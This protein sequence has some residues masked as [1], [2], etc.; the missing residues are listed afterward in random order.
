MKDVKIYPHMMFRNCKFD[1]FHVHKLDVY[2]TGENKWH[3]EYKPA[4]WQVVSSIFGYG[5]TR[6]EARMRIVSRIA[7]M[8]GGPLMVT[9]V[10]PPEFGRF[11][12]EKV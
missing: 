8:V 12:L 7:N 5:P 4:W 3:V 6:K 11:D 2:R 10:Q 1:G 9:D